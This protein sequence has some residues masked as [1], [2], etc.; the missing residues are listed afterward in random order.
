VV[1]GG[2]GL[3]GSLALNPRF[4]EVSAQ[5]AL[6]LVLVEGVSRFDEPGVGPCGKFVGNFCYI[7]II[8]IL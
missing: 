7:F 8:L 3:R 4:R 6:E 1:D 2:V 5:E